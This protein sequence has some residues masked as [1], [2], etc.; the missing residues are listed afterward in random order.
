MSSLSEAQEPTFNLSV[1][2]LPGATFS[3]SNADLDTSVSWTPHPDLL[4]GIRSRLVDA[5]SSLPRKWLLPPIDGEV[6][7][8]VKAAE[9]QLQ[10]YTLAAGFQVVIGQGSTRERRN[11]WCIHH[12]DKTRNDRGL[13]T[14][15]ERDPTDEKIIVSSRKRDD[16]HTWSRRCRWRCYLVPFVEMNESSTFKRWV[17]RYGTNRETALPTTS[18]SYSLTANPFIYP[19]H[20]INHPSYIKAIP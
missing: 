13:S 3:Y 20:R 6:F 7:D 19:K 10:G 12:G 15:V 2:A 1:P 4:E 9:D 8:T 11:F 14:T 16:T 18:H 17:L 5:V